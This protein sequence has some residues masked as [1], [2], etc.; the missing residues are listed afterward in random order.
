[1]LAEKLLKAIPAEDTLYV[2][3]VFSASTYTGNG[4]T[5]S[6]VNGIDLAGEGGMVWQ[7]ERGSPTNLDGS[8]FIYDSAR[9]VNKYLEPHSTGAQGDSSLTQLSA[10]LSNG[11]SLGSSTGNTNTAKYIAWTFRKAPKFFDVVTWTGN[12]T[13][14]TIAHDLGIV[15]GMIEIKKT[16]NTS[17]WT[18][19]HRSLATDDTLKLNTTDAASNTGVSPTSITSTSF[20]IGSASSI[21]N[22]GDTYVAYLYAHDDSDEGII[23]CGSFTTDGSGNATVTLGW[24]PQYILYKNAAATG[25]WSILDTARGYSLTSDAYLFAN[26]TGAESISADSRYPTATGFVANGFGASNTFIYKVIRRSNK[27]PE[28]GTDVYSA[29]SATFVD[30]TAVTTGFP[31]DLIISRY[32][33]GTLDTF[34]YDRLRGGTSGGLYLRTNITN[35]EGATTPYTK[36]WNNT[37]Y[38]IGAGLDGLS[39]VAWAFKRAPGFLDIVCY[40]GTGSAKTEAH[41][42]A[43]VPE[44]IIAKCRSA[45]SLAWLVHA[46]PIGASKTLFLNQTDAESGSSAAYWNSTAPT[47]AVFSLGYHDQNNSSST[48]VAY[49]MATLPG[50]SKVGSYTGNATTNQIDCGFST[51]ARFVL[52]KRTDSTGDWYVWD[53]V[54]GIVSGNDPYLLLNS[55][56]AEVT[57]TDYIDA[58]SAGFEL[59]STAPSAINASGGTFVYWAIA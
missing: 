34:V 54:R 36:A 23:Q 41:N 53:T 17:N 49:L 48:N 43:V 6:I 50:I 55:T 28:V 5:Q 52:I 47:D 8:N 46:A 59:S 4:S 10:F 27:P 29:Y 18:V 12:G 38:V 3:D 39:S 26:S 33:A 7:K 20:D 57:S 2:D 22:S 24:E 44:L 15:P 14:Q 31:P 19:W 11:F 25:S 42:L 51:G 16:N 9:G 35:A 30:G 37:G 21:N 13:S 45:G 58:Y 32:K 56:A 40:A 1:M